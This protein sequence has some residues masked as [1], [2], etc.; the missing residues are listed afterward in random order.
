[1]KR[2]LRTLAT[3]IVVL[4][5]SSCDAC[6]C[7]TNSGTTI[8][9]NP[10]LPIT[11]GRV[12][13][14]GESE[15]SIPLE[16]FGESEDVLDVSSVDIYVNSELRTANLSPSDDYDPST[17]AVELTIG[18][19]VDG[20][21][22]TFIINNSVDEYTYVGTASTAADTEAISTDAGEG[23]DDGGDGGGGEE[24]DVLSYTLAN[25]YGRW[26]EESTCNG[27]PIPLGFGDLEASNLSTLVIGGTGCEHAVYFGGAESGEGFS[28]TATFSVSGTTLSI[29]NVYIGTIAMTDIVF[30][31]TFGENEGADAYQFTGT[32]GADEVTFVYSTDLD[33]TD[34]VQV[35][36]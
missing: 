21:E 30:S 27:S 24:G 5:L 33:D 29:T 1:M 31:G 7:S 34:C 23:G 16:V 35:P 32:L 25:F 17:E 18:D 19:L 2:T 14:A 6:S 15:V 22:I 13:D 3:I 9:G 4:V 8:T 10:T 12:S 20:D 28:A 11:I 26:C 36:L